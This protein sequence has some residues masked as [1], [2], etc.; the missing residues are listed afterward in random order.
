VTSALL[1]VTHPTW[2]RLDLVG[3]MPGWQ[4]REWER[5]ILLSLA[6][7]DVTPA[8]A[9]IT[10]RFDGYTEAWVAASHSSSSLRELIDTSA[11]RVICSC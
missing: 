5:A 11:G 4:A 8:M 2:R 7:R 1:S 3:P 6:D 10:K 9:V